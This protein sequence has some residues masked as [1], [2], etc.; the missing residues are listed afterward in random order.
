MM[1]NLE[2]THIRLQAQMEA[3]QSVGPKIFKLTYSKITR[4]S[5]DNIFVR[6]P[7]GII[8]QRAADDH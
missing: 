7:N 1:N 3:G 4:M 2:W 5:V 6:V 8:L